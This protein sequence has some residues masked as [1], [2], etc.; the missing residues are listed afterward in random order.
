MNI[1]NFK[2]QISLFGNYDDITPSIEV[3]K[4]FMELFADK[5]LIPNRREGIRIDI[6]EDLKQGKNIK[7]VDDSKLN[8]TSIDKSWN[9]N[10]ESNKISFAF[11]DPNLG[12]FEMPTLDYFVEEVNDIIKKIESK[13]PKKN[14]RIGLTTN[15]LID[16]ED[17]NNIQDKLQ[18]NFSFFKGKKISSWTNRLAVTETISNPS[19]EILNV[20][21]DIS[22]IKASLLMNN[23]DS[24]FNG[25]FLTLDINTL[26]E[27]IDYR[28]DNRNIADFLN[29]LK[30]LSIKVSDEIIEFIKE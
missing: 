6:A 13:Y 30:K 24:I 9:I 17:I 2:Y 19:E 21:Y 10:F 23:K 22:M 16:G 3:I 14:N 1:K 27:N 20:V 18:N 5:N 4:Y 8:L 25:L 7:Q 11:T 15:F 28:F 29:E 12:V 26:H